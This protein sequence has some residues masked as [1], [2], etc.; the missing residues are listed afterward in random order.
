MYGGGRESQNILLQ[1]L[2]TSTRRAP[3]RVLGGDA[4]AAAPA[5]R[6]A[7]SLRSRALSS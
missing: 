4:A 3:G 1:M 2:P 5:A 7:P 6:G